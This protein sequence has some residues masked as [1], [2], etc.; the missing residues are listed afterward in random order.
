[1]TS[2]CFPMYSQSLRKQSRKN[3]LNQTYETKQNHIP[4]RKKS[5]Y[6]EVENF[7]QNR[8]WVV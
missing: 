3:T 7:D 2:N 5:F 4:Q 6:N 1:M 8:M